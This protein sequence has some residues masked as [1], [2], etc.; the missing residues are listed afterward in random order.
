[1]RTPKRVR[2]KMYYSSLHEGQPIYE[3]DEE[4]NIIYDQMPD[5]TE[6]P[7]IIGE[8]PEGYDEPTEFENSITG[9]LT[10]D[11]LKAFGNEPQAMAKMTYHKGLFPFV[12]GTLI[13]K[14][15]EVR[16][17]ED[18]TIDETSADYRVIGIQKTGRQFDKALLVT[19]V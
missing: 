10:E 1:M 4:G 13:W 15:S 9:E 12:V 7:R 14:D 3:K 16:Y 5:G 2:Q 8:T 6:E 18:G 17:N 19:I 11:E